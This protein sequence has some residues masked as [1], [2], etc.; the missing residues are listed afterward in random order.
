M[1]I[2]S[3]RIDGSNG[4]WYATVGLSNRSTATRCGNGHLVA[5]KAAIDG[6]LRVQGV[7]LEHWKSWS[8]DPGVD[9]NAASEVRVSLDG[10]SPTTG[11][12]THPDMVTSGAMAYLNAVCALLELE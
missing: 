11:E 12:A 7:V 9:S 8:V 3:L 5:V 4:N 10:E 2:V 1:N 6:A